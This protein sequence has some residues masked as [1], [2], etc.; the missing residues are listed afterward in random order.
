MLFSSKASTTPMTKVFTTVSFVEISKASA[1]TWAPQSSFRVISRGSSTI[2]MKS[3]P[4]KPWAPS[5]AE[6]PRWLRLRSPA[7]GFARRTRSQRDAASYLYNSGGARS[8]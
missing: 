1:H 4:W 3:G 6:P 8:R 2:T 5:G 7:C